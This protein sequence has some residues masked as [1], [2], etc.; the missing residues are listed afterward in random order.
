MCRSIPHL[1]EEKLRVAE[2]NVFSF[3]KVLRKIGDAFVFDDHRSHPERVPWS[4]HPRYGA[5]IN[6]Y[7]TEFQQ[8]LQKQV[9]PAV[10]FGEQSH[11][12]EQLTEEVIL[13]NQGWLADTMLWKP[14]NG[15]RVRLCKCLERSRERICNFWSDRPEAGGLLQICSPLQSNIVPLFVGSKERAFVLSASGAKACHIAKADFMN[16][17]AGSN[18]LSL[19]RTAQKRVSI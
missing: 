8:R 19:G 18:S 13:G 16:S 17:A 11:L 12:I 5:T 1:L 9:A 14:S 4:N 2:Q 6:L 15:R 10:T 3:E 7:D